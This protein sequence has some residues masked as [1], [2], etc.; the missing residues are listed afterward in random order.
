MLIASHDKPLIVELRLN[1]VMNLKD[2]GSAKKILGMKIQGDHRVGTLF[3]S[4]K[5]YIEKVLEKYNL[6][7]YKSVATPFA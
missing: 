1:L 7:N 6:N 4:Q 5:S 2:L 3:L